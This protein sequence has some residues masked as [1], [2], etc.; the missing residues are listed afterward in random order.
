MQQCVREPPRVLANSP[1]V[2]DA[3][4]HFDPGDVAERTSATVTIRSSAPCSSPKAG[5]ARWDREPTACLSN[6]REC[7]G[8]VS[9]PAA[10]GAAWGG[11]AE[12]EPMANRRGGLWLYALPDVVER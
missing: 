3:G 7:C 9:A 4:D 1:K 2:H 8:F 11:A 12:A 5:R 6:A 10:L